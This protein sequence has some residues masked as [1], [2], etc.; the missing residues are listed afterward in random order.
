MLPAEVE[1]FISGCVSRGL[2][3]KPLPVSIMVNRLT[4]AD[5]AAGRIFAR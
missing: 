2:K 1:D 5:P 4:P 3:P